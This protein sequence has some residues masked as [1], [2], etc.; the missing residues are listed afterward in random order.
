M[1]SGGPGQKQNPIRV[2][3]SKY[4]DIKCACGSKNFLMAFSLKIIPALITGTGKEE[5]FTTPQFICVECSS[6]APLGV[7][8]EQKAPA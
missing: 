4:P 5:L 8:N 2:D 3:V 6:V 1:Q 7:T